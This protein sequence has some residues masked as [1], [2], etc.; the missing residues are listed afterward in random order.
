M[1]ILHK[2]NLFLKV[3]SII[4]LA[5]PAKDAVASVN[6]V[7]PINSFLISFTLFLKYY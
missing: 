6:I 2:L 1:V 4:F 7:I 5:H 3:F